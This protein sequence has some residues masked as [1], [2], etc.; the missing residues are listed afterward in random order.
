MHRSRVLKRPFSKR[1]ASAQIQK[2]IAQLE[3][4]KSTLQTGLN[5]Q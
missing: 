5:N 1:T 2:A 4:G 3:L